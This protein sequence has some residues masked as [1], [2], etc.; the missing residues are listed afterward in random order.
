MLE[1]ARAP[2]LVTQSALL[3][4]IARAWRAASCAS[5]PTGPPS[6]AQPTTAPASGLEPQNPAYVIYTSG[7]TGTPKGVASTHGGIANLAAVQI[8]R[9]AITSAARVL[10]FAS[11][12][13]DAALSEMSR[14]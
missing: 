9:F 10:Q 12:S 5:T 14:L 11:Q 13:F 8:D 6:R 4:A 1:D 2:V 7:S 3:D